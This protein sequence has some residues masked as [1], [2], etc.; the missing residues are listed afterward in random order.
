M[1]ILLSAGITATATIAAGIGIAATTAAGIMTDMTAVI[2]VGTA[3]AAAAIVSGSTTVIHGGV[4]A[5]LMS[6][7][8]MG[9]I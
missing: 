3:I 5:V 2:G 1:G 4:S 6:P 8:S 9:F 7:A